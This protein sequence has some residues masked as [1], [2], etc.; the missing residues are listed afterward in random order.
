[1]VESGT[2]VVDVISVMWTI[3]LVC[4]GFIVKVVIALSFSF[5]LG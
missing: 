5:V 4:K 2:S 3:L 1:M